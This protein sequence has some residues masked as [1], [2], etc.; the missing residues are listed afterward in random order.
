MPPHTIEANN[1]SFAVCYTNAKEGKRKMAPVEK[2]DVA[3]A[4][5]MRASVKATAVKRAKQ[6]GRS[7]ANY[8]E[9]LIIADSEK[10]TK[11]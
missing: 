4:L 10:A 1:L 9:R 6:E 5:R 8:I 7:L 11:R 2:R 3:V